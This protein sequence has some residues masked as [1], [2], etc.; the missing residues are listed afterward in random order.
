MK[1]L[2]AFALGAGAVIIGRKICHET[3][4][5]LPDITAPDGSI[6]KGGFTTQPGMAF[7]SP[8]KYPFAYVIGAAAIGGL[9]GGA[10][11]ALAGA[12]GAG[13]GIVPWG[14]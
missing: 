11:G 8:T 7:C 12:A 13:F 4:S 1:Y 14:L 3:M 10:G 6:A 2:F 5:K 9:I